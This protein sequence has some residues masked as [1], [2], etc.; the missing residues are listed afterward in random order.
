MSRIIKCKGSLSEISMK[1]AR[2][3]SVKAVLVG[4]KKDEQVEGQSRISWRHESQKYRECQSRIGWRHREQTA[5]PHHEDAD[6]DPRVG[7]N[8][9]GSSS[10][11]G[12]KCTVEVGTGVVQETD[13]TNVKNE[14]K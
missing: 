13:L 9:L 8:V 7:A 1:M 10:I 4:H 14:K 11:E 5:T 12:P 3:R 2:R 6:G